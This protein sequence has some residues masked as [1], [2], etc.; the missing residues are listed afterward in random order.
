MEH[1]LTDRQLMALLA[2]YYGE[3]PQVAASG[4]YGE[5]HEKAGRPFWRG[6]TSM[7]GAVRRMCDKLR[8]EGLVTDWDHRSEHHEPYYDHGNQL[9]VKGYEAIEERIGKLPVVKDYW[10]GKPAFDFNTDLSVVTL[11]ERK[12][13]RRAREAEIVRLRAEKQAHVRA[14]IIAGNVERRQR[15]LAELRKIFDERGLAGN[16]SDDELLTFAKQVWEAR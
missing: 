15:Q 12:E 4:V 7:G 14:E 6:R 10:S 1:K 13:Q 2:I 3:G 11:R 8:E 5:T 16:W 9:T